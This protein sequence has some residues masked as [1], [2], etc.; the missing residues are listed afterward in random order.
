[1]TLMFLVL[2]KLSF[3]K[4]EKLA[5]KNHLAKKQTLKIK[6]IFQVRWI[7]KARQTAA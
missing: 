1:M 5:G 3:S 4:L 6:G 2:L 7:C